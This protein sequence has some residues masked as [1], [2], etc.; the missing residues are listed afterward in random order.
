MLNERS[1]FQV[2]AANLA[3]GLAAVERFMASTDDPRHILQGLEVRAARSGIRIGASNGVV[4]AWVNVDVDGE[5]VGRPLR[6]PIVASDVWT[7]QGMLRE[8]QAIETITIE[9]LRDRVMIFSR[10]GGKMPLPVMPTDS[11]LWDWD[12]RERVETKRFPNLDRVFPK[13][14][15]RVKWFEVCPKAISWAIDLVKAELGRAGAVKFSIE[16]L[17]GPEPDEW[18][19]KIKGRNR[20]AM[21]P[22]GETNAG[23]VAAD[24]KA[25]FNRTLLE[26]FFWF[27]GALGR[28]VRIYPGEDGWEPLLVEDVCRE[29]RFLIMPLRVEEWPEEAE[30]EAEK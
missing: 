1:R 13:R 27:V 20:G 2:C 30:E 28:Y 19:V 9:G 22:V 18:V 15:D 23:K 12:G 16:P 4:A 29:A 14:K 25:T 7:I 10:A 11:R 6:C 5:A 21:I 26:Q 17:F 24:Y 8:C 3:R